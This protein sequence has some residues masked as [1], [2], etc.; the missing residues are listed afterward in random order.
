MLVWRLGYRLAPCDFPPRLLYAWTN[1]FDDPSHEYRTLYCADKKETCLREVLADLRPNTKAISEFRGLFGSG[2]EEDESFG[3]VTKGWRR[4]NVLARA[5]IETLSGTV[6]DVENPSVRKSLERRL[7]EFLKKEG[8]RHL[9]PRELR[10]KKRHVTK[11]ISRAVFDAGHA[12]IKFHSHLD[13]LPC[14]AL[15]E[16]RAQ[17]NQMGEMISLQEN[18]PELVAVCKEFNLTLQN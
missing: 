9:N 14:Y 8:V 18:V 3:K 16:F 17:L 4:Q 6:V 2:G 15:F 7:A 1:R 5:G 13:S 12:G 10:S 11:R